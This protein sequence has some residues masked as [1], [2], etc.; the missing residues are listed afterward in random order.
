MSP[1]RLQTWWLVGPGGMYRSFEPSRNSATAGGS[2]AYAIRA[3]I[4]TA[5]AADGAEF[6]L[7]SVREERRL[8]APVLVLEASTLRSSTT[9]RSS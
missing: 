7:A 1:S 3:R 2:A 8:A 5:L 9:N 6:T 4:P